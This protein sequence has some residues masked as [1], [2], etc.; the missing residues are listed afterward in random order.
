MSLFVAV[1]TH[2]SSIVSS[3][4]VP[5]NCIMVPVPDSAD[6]ELQQATAPKSPDGGP[7]LDP[8]VPIR[9]ELVVDGKQVQETFTWNAQETDLTPHMFARLMAADLGLPESSHEEIVTAMQD[10]IDAFVPA[11]RRRVDGGESRQVVRLDMRIGRVVIR[12]QFEWDLNSTENCPESFAAQLCAELG[13]HSEFVPSVAHAVREQLNELAE[14]EDKRPPRPALSARSVVR[15]P[16]DAAQWE[17]VVE[18]LSVDDQVRLERKEK[19]EARLQR[20]NRG[21]ADVYGK[22][23]S[24]IRYHD[25]STARRRASAQSFDDSGSEAETTRSAGRRSE[26]KRRRR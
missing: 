3:R 8:L 10:Q 5:V 1:N 4:V 17:P 11:K 6:V 7:L 18:C 14:F 2:F 12:D 9:L 21:K 22:P 13:L 24:R 19:R 15:M 25:P 26:G 20:R 16:E 23:T